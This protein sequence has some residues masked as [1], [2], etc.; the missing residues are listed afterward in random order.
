MI[1]SL[2]RPEAYNHAVGP[3]QLLETH[4]SW[5]LLTGEYAYKIKKPVDLGFVDFS[6][7]EKRRW[8]CEEEVRLNRRLAADLY[9]GVC[10]IHGP[11]DRASFAGSGPVIDWAV[12]MRQFPQEALM[13]AALEAGRI[14]PRHWIELADRLAAFQAAAAVVRDGEA[15]TAGLGTPEVVRAVAQA[16]LEAL[17]VSPEARDARPALQRWTDDTMARLAPLVDRRRSGGRVREGHGDLHLGNMVFLD[18]RIR[19]FDCL[20]FN[21]DLRWI[22]VISELAFLVMD[23]AGHGREPD[24]VRVLNRWLDRTGDYTGLALW[25]WYVVYRALVRAKVAALRQQQAGPAS[26]EAPALAAAVSDYVRQAEATIDA[27]PGQLVI[28]RGV[29]GS[30]KS[31]VSRRLCDH[32]GWIHLR[33]DA[34]R[35]RLFGHWGTG[36]DEAGPVDVP[37]LYAPATTE[38]LFGEVLPEQAESVLRAGFSVVVDATFLKARH[39]RVMAEVARRCGARF[40]ILDCPVAES[41]ARDRIGHRRQLGGDPSDADA[42]VLAGQGTAMEP[43]S[44]AEQPV[45]V[46]VDTTA[47]DLELVTA[48]ALRESP[49]S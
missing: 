22:D 6:S 36:V 2:R 40:R 26:P 30:G 44:P 25:R 5:V 16:N 46:T 3:I 15:G 32:L 27:P 14:E 45:T 23:L 20:E 48:A 11:A 42:A 7:L 38:R 17:A 47:S 1:G 33:S 29:S 18:D 28:T 10:A 13:S 43:L 39:R 37:Q 35:K 41:V 31:H 19:V 9:L 24:G 4:I 8:F 49:D 12:Q 34:E 21:A